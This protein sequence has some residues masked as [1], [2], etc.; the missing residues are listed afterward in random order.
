MPDT[1]GNKV[2]LHLPSDWRSALVLPPF[3]G[4]LNHRIK[5]FYSALTPK[6]K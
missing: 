6:K 5:K 3:K 1:V 2:D 4:L